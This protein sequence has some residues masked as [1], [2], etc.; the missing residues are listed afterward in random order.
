M[1]TTSVYSIPNGGQCKTSQTLEFRSSGVLASIQNGTVTLDVREVC[2]VV[3]DVI[4]AG[5]GPAGLTASIYT[6][7]A[8]L[9]VKIVDPSGAGGQAGTTSII[10]NYPG[11]PDGVSGPELMGFMSEQAKLSGLR[12]NTVKLAPSERKTV[13]SWS[14]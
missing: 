9:K 6:A 5:G 11:F 12:L 3:Q 1:S 10:H 13:Y 14:P 4:I 7:R 2:P 8:G